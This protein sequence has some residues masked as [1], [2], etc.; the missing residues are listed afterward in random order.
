MTVSTMA[1]RGGVRRGA[2]LQVAPRCLA[3]A[4][5][6]HPQCCNWKI[7]GAYSSALFCSHTESETMR[8]WLVTHGAPSLDR[9]RLAIG[10]TVILLTLPLHLVGVSIDME[11]E[12]QQNDSL[13]DGYPRSPPSFAVPL[14]VHCRRVRFHCSVAA[15]QCCPTALS[16]P[17]LAAPLPLTECRRCRHS[18]DRGRHA[19]T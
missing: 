1:R 12:C 11:R 8:D 10:E 5:Q 18:A 7:A 15:F 19:R 9:P 13:A 6:E 2:R 4:A 14:L 16:P 3:A 17:S